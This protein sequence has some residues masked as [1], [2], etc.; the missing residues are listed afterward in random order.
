MQIVNYFLAYQV[1]ASMQ[2]ASSSYTLPVT[3]NG[4][5]LGILTSYNSKDQISDVIAPEI[6]SHVVE[7][8]VEAGPFGAKGAG[9]LPSIPTSA[10]IT[11]A[12]YRATGVR[13][14]SLPVDQDELLRACAA[15]AETIEL[16]WGDL[17]PIPHVALGGET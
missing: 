6:V 8:A 7:H 11:N 14:R 16:G 13:V 10:A 1:K 17:E 5:L 15:G 9:E 2:S 12:I 3:R 4:R